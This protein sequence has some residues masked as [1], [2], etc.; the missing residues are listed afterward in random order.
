MN[1]PVW[2]L[3]GKGLR[4]SGIPACSGVLSAL[5]WLSLRQLATRE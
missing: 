3:A 5:R 1:L 2:T 4:N